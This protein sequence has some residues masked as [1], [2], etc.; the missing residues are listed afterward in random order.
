M[1]KKDKIILEEIPID[2]GQKQRILRKIAEAAEE[3][4]YAYCPSFWE[5]FHG[6]L[7]YISSF[8]LGGQII[9]FLLFL[10]VLGYFQSQGVGRTVYLG[11]GSASSSC[12][13]VFLMMELSRSRDYGVAELEQACYLDLK[14]VWCIKMILF[15][16]LD[17]LTLTAMAFGIAGNTS[18]HMIRIIV[19]LLAP[20]VLS[21]ALQLLVFTFLRSRKGEYL[22]M[23]AAAFAS[24]MSLLPLDHPNWYTAPYF[25]IWVC[26]LA[27]ALAFLA[28]EIVQLYHNLEE[29]E[30]ICWS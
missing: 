7:K 21:N 22:Q 9:C 16:S 10:A 24:G 27:A 3:K 13:G 20:F 14:Q 8:C 26:V 17:I 18:L 11:I 4:R 30:G 28:R 25:G 6:Q 1:K 29:G 2:T 12:I 5:I 15:G 23:G 19:Y